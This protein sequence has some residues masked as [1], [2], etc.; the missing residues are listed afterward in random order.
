MAPYLILA[1]AAA[2]LGFLLCELH[3]SRRNDIIFLTVMSVV[4]FFFSILRA[5]SVGVDYKMYLDFYWEEIGRASCRE[6]V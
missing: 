2:L 6:R 5:T 3:P 4:M 1:A